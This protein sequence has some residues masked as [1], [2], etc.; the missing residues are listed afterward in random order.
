MLVSDAFQGPIRV[1]ISYSHDSP[2]H[3]QR[4]LALSDRLCSE[5]VDCH[6]DQYEVSPP[7]GWPRWMRDQIAKARFVLVVCTEAYQ[8]RVYGREEP[9]RGRGATWEGAI[10]TQ[11]LY[12]S[13]G[14]NDKFIP[15]VFRSEDLAYKPEFIGGATHYDVS[16]EAGYD[17]LYRH[18]TSQPR[19]VK[20]RLGQVR[21]LPEENA[22]THP[23]ASGGSSGPLAATPRMT[24]SARK[25]D[26]L[27]LLMSKQGGIS[28]FEAAEIEAGDELRLRLVPADAR[29]SAFLDSLRKASDRSLG[30]AF[31][32]TALLADIRTVS[33]S[34]TG[35]RETWT[36]VLS[37]QETDY[38]AGFM[39]M[40]TT[41]YT[42]DQLA[43]LRGRRVLL[44][45]F[46]PKGIGARGS[47]AH[48]SFLEVLIQGVSTALKPSSSP[49]P[50]LY[51]QLK[52][53]VP[54]FLAAARLLGV[55]YLRLSGVVEQIHRLDL[56]FRPPASLQVAFEGRRSKKFI[57]QDPAL[58]RISG[59]CRLA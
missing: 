10:I 48:D 53:D 9:G 58:I 23:I 27:V 21:R 24:L 32:L 34:I 11:A 44:D 43:E 30:V 14:R 26:S 4:V 39:E 37:P 16:T 15:V 19:V 57:N 41:G 46:P 45:E 2:E 3:G 52:D 56:E 1:F 36:L 49:F 47:D 22:S 31:A 29:E 40:G 59:T 20:P 33:R 54:L 28:L 50:E 12:D 25:L 35:G 38:G 7:E 51:T 8:R 6:I 18:L 42:A 13:G 5:G 55:L 17:G